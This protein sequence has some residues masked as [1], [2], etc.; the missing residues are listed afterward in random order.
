MK[1]YQALKEKNKIINKINELTIIIQNK[2]STL[3]TNPSNFNLHEILAE[4]DSQRELLVSLKTRIY[5]TNMP[6]QHKIFKLAELKAEIK[7]W[8]SLNTK[9]GVEFER[10]SKEKFEYTAH[11]NDV[12][13]RNKKEEL[14]KE[15]EKIQEELDYFNHVTDLI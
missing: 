15:I 6:I 10:F 12:F 13:V 7:F 3:K 14:Q 8:S 4:L 5:K 2:N 9:E 11:F 1:L